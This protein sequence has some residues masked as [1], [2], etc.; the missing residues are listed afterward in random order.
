LLLAG[1]GNLLSVGA[2]ENA[3][4]A[5]R[6]QAAE[7]HHLTKVAHVLNWD[8]RTMMSPAGA[9]ARAA[10]LA[11]VTRILHELLVSDETAR[12]LE[13]AEV[14]EDG[15]EYDS[16]D[17]SLIRFLRREREK[18]RRVPASLRAEMSAAAS[19]ALPVWERARAESDFE[20]FRPYLE[21]NVELR[22][23]YV[24]CL[25]E[26]DEPYDHLLD[27]YE[28]G[29]KTAEVRAVFDELKEGLV[30]LIA[31]IGEREPVDTSCLRGPFELDRQHELERRVLEAFGFTRE[32]W[33]IDET[34]HP[35]ASSSSVADIRLTSRHRPDDLHSL[36]A[37][38]HEFGH[39]LY[40]R[41]VGLELEGTPLARGCSLVIHESQSRMWEN[42][43]GR[44]APFWRWCYPS[45][46]ELFPSFRDV[47]LDEFY[48]AINA[49]RPSLIRIEA[50]EAT[51]NLHIVLRFELEQE[52]IAGNGDLRDLPERWDA[53]MREYLG[54]EVPDVADGLLQ[55]MHWAAG[56][57]GY[58][59]TYS[60]GNIVSCQL[61]ERIRA[62]L[63]DLDEQLEQGDFGPLREWLREHVH[64]HGRKFL[65][66]ELLG[67][68]VGGG[69]D[70]QPYLRYLRA[71]LGA[72]YALA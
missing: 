69:I 57:I 19:R 53:K 68:V 61:W 10:Q 2:A 47:E 62:D 9:P 54:V 71:K 39:G 4:T 40:E 29:M 72:I 5:L 21:R 50:D 1:G 20:S 65:P 58:F 43:V 48:R 34:V 15:L 25:G 44:S 36:F 41:Q 35:F 60:L 66:G 30:P 6:S 59:S 12:L 32:S 38:M 14:H 17:A 22:R 52:L 8:Q 45:L 37:T 46:R 70:P 24:A 55:D 33:R 63:A 56:H 3:L 28:P 31:E 67:R 13:A 51:Y 64:R 42:L 23:E 7:L 18:A 49:V 11:T 26:A 27:D 16:D